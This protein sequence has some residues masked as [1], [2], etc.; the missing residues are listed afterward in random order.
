MNVTVLVATYILTGTSKPGPLGPKTR[1]APTFHSCP[2][3][4][5]AVRREWLRSECR[6][7]A[8]AGSRSSRWWSPAASIWYAGA[9]CDPNCSSSDR[10]R[11]HTRCLSCR[12]WR[13]H[14]RHYGSIWSSLDTTKMS[15]LAYRPCSRSRAGFPAR[16]RLTRT[17][18]LSFAHQ[19]G[20]PQLWGR[21]QAGAGA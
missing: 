14:C 2:L 13:L 19:P 16:L 4:R 9:S 17:R 5:R 1:V 8:C 11:A 12:V 20:S 3:V 18:L 15:T 7:C 21:L 10:G 6:A